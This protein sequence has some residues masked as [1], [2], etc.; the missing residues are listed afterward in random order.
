MV[1]GTTC[2]V[3]TTLNGQVIAFTGIVVSTCP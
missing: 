3:S 1:T 2:S